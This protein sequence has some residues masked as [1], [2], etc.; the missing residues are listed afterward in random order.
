MPEF[1]NDFFLG[2]GA[3]A[4]KRVAPTFAPAAARINFLITMNGQDGRMEQFAPETFRIDADHWPA[5]LARLSAETGGDY[6]HFRRSLDADYGIVTRD[7]ALG[8]GALVLIVG[9]V[10]LAPGII[11]GLAAAGAGAI[12]V[13]LAIA[14]LQLF[15]HEAAHWNLAAD[16]KQSDRIANALIC[17]QVGTSIAAYRRVHFDHHRHLGHA[18]DGERS[19][20]RALNWRLIAEM[21]TG[22]HALRI[23][24]ARAKASPATGKAPAAPAASLRPLLR[25]IAVHALIL[26]GLL[27]VGAWAS[28]LAWT[29]GMAIFFPL[30]ATLRP[31]LEHRPA[32]SDTSALTGPRAAVTRMFDDGLLARIFGGAGFN[33]HLLHHWEPQVSYTRL[34]ALDRYLA[35]TSVGS[36]VEA[37]R[38]TYV[39]AFRDLLASD[40]GR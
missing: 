25:G 18:D 35:R 37:R 16:R 33:R 14:Y 10:A 26:V 27:A 11:G 6:H 21:V 3:L 28:A 12:A 32:A 1:R 34:A 29:G 39:Q 4:V 22:I 30:F 40:H 36:I 9:L 8:Y 24:V 5:I 38:T 15:I 2:S 13:G 23:F 20:V 19:Y 17:W 7:I 31:L